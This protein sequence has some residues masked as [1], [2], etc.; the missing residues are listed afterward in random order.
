[1]KKFVIPSIILLAGLALVGCSA[2]TGVGEA[3]NNPSRSEETN[4]SKYSSVDFNEELKNLNINTDLV[5]DY[6]WIT[7]V[8]DESRPGQSVIVSSLNQSTAE[9]KTE[10]L[11]WF[12][13]EFS[14][15]GEIVP[16]ETPQTKHYKISDEENARGIFLQTEPITLLTIIVPKDK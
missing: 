1:M 10:I 12:T 16:S 5:A 8:D 7:Y 9:E 14:D 11:N 13:E 3:Q 6:D 15:W 2:Q 4:S